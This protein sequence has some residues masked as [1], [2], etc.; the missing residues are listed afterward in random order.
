MKNVKI[1]GLA[2]VLGLA[3]ALGACESGD[4]GSGD[5]TNPAATTP[6]EPADTGATTPAVVPTPEATATP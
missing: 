3:T 2:L 6:A 4:T 5:T 1:L